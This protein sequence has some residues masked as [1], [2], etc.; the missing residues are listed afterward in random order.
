MSKAALYDNCPSVSKLAD[1]LISKDNLKLDWAINSF[2]LDV[3]MRKK[4]YRLCAKP[5]QSEIKGARVRL[6]ET[7]VIVVLKKKNPDIRWFCLQTATN[8]A[9]VDEE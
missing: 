8:T 2:T 9:N 7:K 6:R 1:L 3:E 4:T 5:L